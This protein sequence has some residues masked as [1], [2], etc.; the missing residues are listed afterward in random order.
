MTFALGL[1]AKPMLVT[2]PCA[3]LLLDSGHCGALKILNG[4]G[5]ISLCCWK[6]GRSFSSPPLPAPSRFW[7]SRSRVASAVVS[8]ET[9]PAT[10][11]AQ[12]RAAGLCRYLSKTF[13]P[14]RLAIFYPLHEKIPA[15]CGAASAVVLVL[16]SLAALRLRHTRP[17]LL[18]GWL[19]FLGML[20][21]VIGLVQVGSAAL[22]T[23]TPICGRRHFHRRHV[24]RVRRLP[25]GSKSQTGARGNCRLHP[26]R[27]APSRRKTSFAIAEQ[28]HAFQH[29]LAVTTDNDVARDNLGVALNS[30]AGSPRPPNNTAS[31]RASSRPLPGHHK[32]SRTCSPPRPSGGGAGRTSRGR[33]AQPGHA[34]PA[35]RPRAG[36]RHRRQG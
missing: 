3:L 20:V 13:W 30:R 34:V 23:V 18:T 22:A 31:P 28:R 11:P 19:W 29:A 2:L 7:P 8:L 35:S 14:A 26:R 32:S 16:I 24:C 1:M 21:P 6:N 12:E 15:I 9:V 10:L 5:Q 4:R 27:L 33:A 25:R 17:Y 36:A